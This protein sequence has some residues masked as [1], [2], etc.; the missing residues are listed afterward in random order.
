MATCRQCGF[1][2]ASAGEVCNGC[3]VRRPLLVLVPSPRDRRSIAGEIRP[4]IIA[5]CV[6][7]LLLVGSRLAVGYY[8]AEHQANG[9]KALALE[10]LSLHR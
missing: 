2:G 8:A 3:H 1:T 9:V 7:F 10:E 6:F 5:G 4:F